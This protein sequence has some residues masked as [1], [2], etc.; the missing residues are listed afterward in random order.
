MLRMRGRGILEIGSSRTGGL[1]SSS[2]SGTSVF[3]LKSQKCTPYALPI[4]DGESRTDENDRSRSTSM[5]KRG[6]FDA[7]LE[8]RTI[9]TLSS[10]SSPSLVVLGSR[11]NRTT[12]PISFDPL[13]LPLGSG[14]SHPLLPHRLYCTEDSRYRLVQ[15]LR[16]RR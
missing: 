9:S 6:L 10:K 4:H 7:T 12:I 15:D 3:P 8:Q 16:G 14:V 1:G 2:S 13:N 5:E 11:G